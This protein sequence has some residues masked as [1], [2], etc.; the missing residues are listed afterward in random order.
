MSHLP[1]AW[2]SPMGSPSFK[3]PPLALS[4]AGGTDLDYG[5]ITGA[6]IGLLLMVAAFAAVGLY[7][8]CLTD[9]PAVAAVITFGLLFMLWIISWATQVNPDSAEL[10]RWLSIVQH[11]DNFQHGVINSTDAMYYL[12]MMAVFLLLSVRRL[13]AGRLQA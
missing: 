11:Q 4:L 9:H 10:L 7:V 5:Q 12:I 2:S 13:D 6:A 8:S 1:V 3:K